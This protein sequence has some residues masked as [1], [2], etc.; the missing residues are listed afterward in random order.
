M[1]QAGAPAG[2][3]A[4][5]TAS[6][7]V[8]HHFW[9]DD[10]NRPKYV[11]RKKDG[12]LHSEEVDEESGLLLPAHESWRSDGTLF[13]RDWYRDGL[14]HR[15]E[16]DPETA[17]QLPAFQIFNRNGALTDK[18]WYV[19]GELFCIDEAHPNWCE[20]GREYWSYSTK[21]GHLSHPLEPTAEFMA[22]WEE[23][24]AR[25]AHYFDPIPTTK[26]ARKR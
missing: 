2:T 25:F 16:R 1:A 9:D 22:I 20:R 24:R 5:T 8:V 11:Q 18:W 15:T 21:E 19:E 13:Y 17:L 14:P 10:P 6:T 4:S 7:T 23:Q 3:T 12:K 26:A